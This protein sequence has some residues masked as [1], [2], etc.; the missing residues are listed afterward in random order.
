MPQAPMPQPFPSSSLAKSLSRSGARRRQTTS[1]DPPRR[2]EAQPRAAGAA[3]TPNSPDNQSQVRTR[4]HDLDHRSHRPRR[5]GTHTAL[6][7]TEAGHIRVL[8]RD[9]DAV[10]PDGTHV[11]MV[12]GRLELSPPDTLDENPTADRA[13]PGARSAHTA[14]RHPQPARRGAELDEIH[15][16]RD[17]RRRRGPQDGLICNNMCT[18]R[19]S[20]AA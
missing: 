17:A 6:L 9:P 3:P 20:P 8:T 5:V 11:R 2:R 15:Q 19:C 12:N 18:P 16:P 1:A 14:D 13:P 7:P 10:F 4:T